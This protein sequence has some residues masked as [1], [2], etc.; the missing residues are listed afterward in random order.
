MQKTDKL[1]GDYSKGFVHIA[2]LKTTYVRLLLEHFAQCLPFLECNRKK[3]S[4][5][6]NKS[7]KS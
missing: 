3:Y 6:L 4:N 5:I 1:I 7:R 2:V